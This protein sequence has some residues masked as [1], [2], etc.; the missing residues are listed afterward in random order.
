MKFE[1]RLFV[2][3]ISC[4]NIT[5]TIS[6]SN[7]QK[8]GVGSTLVPPTLSGEPRK[9]IFL[10]RDVWRGFPISFRLISLFLMFN[11]TQQYF[12]ECNLNLSSLI[13]YHDHAIDCRL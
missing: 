13:V 6:T 3:R 4:D 5:K 11:I 9:C 2:I 10:Q 12:R 7:Y 8:L 1:V